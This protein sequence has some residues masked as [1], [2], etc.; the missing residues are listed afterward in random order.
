MSCIQDPVTGELFVKCP[1]NLD[2][3]SVEPVIDSSRYFVIRV[4]DP[5]SGSHAFLGLG[6]A[7]RS[8]AFD[9]NVAL[10]DH[11][12]Y[13]LIPYEFLCLSLCVCHSKTG[14][15]GQPTLSNP[16][17]ETNKPQADYSLREGQ[18]I[19]INLGHVLKKKPRA[20][21]S[22]GDLAKFS[23][24]LPPPPRPGIPVSVFPT[25]DGFGSAT[26]GDATEFGDFSK[27]FM[28]AAQNDSTSS[29]H[30]P[31]STSDVTSATQSNTVP[32]DWTT[33]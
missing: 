8:W 33:F 19:Q 22:S 10:Q 29:T 4:V 9:L 23:G 18:T 12:K 6:L 27:A 14:Q 31:T 25:N 13:V 30:F 2:G 16:S 28:P 20:E 32:A 21:G 5:A 24:L 26:Q 15:S 17:P 7:E 3:S 1:Y 11:V